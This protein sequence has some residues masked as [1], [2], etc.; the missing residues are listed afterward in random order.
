MLELGY[1]AYDSI[2]NDYLS[3]SQR[4]VIVLPNAWP[5]WQPCLVYAPRFLSSNDIRGFTTSIPSILCLSN[6]HYSLVLECHPTYDA[7]FMLSRRHHRDHL[8]WKL[9]T[10]GANLESMSTNSVLLCYLMIL[11]LVG[12]GAGIHAN[13][14]F[15]IAVKCLL[16]V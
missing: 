6:G 10:I 13:T 14:W 2:A 16:A 1:L 15:C 8:P 12:C 11:E 4:S 9:W 3:R 7:S 5:C